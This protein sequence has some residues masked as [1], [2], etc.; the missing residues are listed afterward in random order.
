MYSL[1]YTPIFLHTHSGCHPVHFLFYLHFER[2][3]LL[4]GPCA[5]PFPPYFAQYLQP[6]GFFFFSLLSSCPIF[7]RM[8]DLRDVVHFCCIRGD[9]DRNMDREGERQLCHIYFYFCLRRP[10]LGAGSS[11][12]VVVAAF[13]LSSSLFDWYCGAAGLCCTKCCSLVIP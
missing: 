3:M 5:R 11:L 2:G 12:S 13:S 4:G 1:K 6:V 7:V 10:L 8:W 9:G